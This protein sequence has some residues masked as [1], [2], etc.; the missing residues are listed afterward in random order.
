MLKRCLVEKR[1]SVGEKSLT[2]KSNV[3]IICYVPKLKAFL[4]IKDIQSIGKD[5]ISKTEIKSG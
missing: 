5:K 2:F 3:E 1:M 4:E